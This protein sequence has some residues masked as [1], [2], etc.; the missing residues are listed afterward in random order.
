MPEPISAGGIALDLGRSSVRSLD[1]TAVRAELGDGNY[2]L[3]APGESL[4]A[5]LR[6]EPEE[7][8]VV[9]WLRRGVGADDVLGLP[10][11]GPASL[12]FVYALKLLRAA[13]PSVAGA[14]PLMLR[15]QREVRANAAPHTL[16]D[17]PAEAEG[18]DARRALRRLVRDL[19]PDRFSNGAPARLLRAS[20][21][22]VS[23]LVSAEARVSSRRPS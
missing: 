1:T 11:C 18:R 16:L 21:E 20:G 7:R 15:K 10:G 17:L 19:H 14:Y 13:S 3:T 6:L 5:S 23:A 4:V 12:R 8:A 9:F 2:R 22:I